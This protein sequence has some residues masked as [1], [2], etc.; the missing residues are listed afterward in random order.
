MN[1]HVLTFYHFV[2]HDQAMQDIGADLKSSLQMTGQ[3]FASSSSSAPTTSINTSVA[4]AVVVPQMPSVFG[5]IAPSQSLP[6]ASSFIRSDPPPRGPFQPQA[7]SNNNSLPFPPPPNSGLLPL[8]TPPPQ[9]QNSSAPS[10]Y[11]DNRGQNR[12]NRR[13][14]WWR[15]PQRPLPG[16]IRPEFFSQGPNSGPF[17]M[18]SPTNLQRPISEKF[19]EFSVSSTTS[20]S[21]YPGGNYD[22]R[23]FL[24]GRSGV[25]PPR[26]EEPRRDFQQNNFVGGGGG[27]L[28]RV[29]WEARVLSSGPPPPAPLAAV[30]PGSSNFVE[31]LQPWFLAPVAATPAPPLPSILQNGPQNNFSQSSPFPPRDFHGNRYNNNDHGPRLHG[32]GFDIGTQNSRSMDTNQQQLQRD[33]VFPRT[34]QN[35]IKGPIGAGQGNAHAPPVVPGDHNDDAHSVTSSTSTRSDRRSITE[36]SAPSPKPS[37]KEPQTIDAKSMDTK[38]TDNSDSPLAPHYSSS[39]STITSS[40]RKRLFSAMSEGDAQSTSIRQDSLGS[41]TRT[42]LSAHSPMS[43]AERAKSSILRHVQQN[44]SRAAAELAKMHD[45]SS[46]FATAADVPEKRSSSSFGECV[47][48]LN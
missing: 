48:H 33:P 21:G 39:D 14:D 44:A 40:S 28:P 47:V 8:P 46:S 5:G 6:A 13:S 37:E 12:T 27:G 2:F 30:P 9:Q 15:N 43:V 25:A 20:S 1:R 41:P 3:S 42:P 36:K 7:Y 10:R 19:P 16:R 32:P 17:P 31:S 4:R 26:H 38:Q 29:P 22:W 45:P 11:A 23:G 34:D 35:V 18:P 24:D